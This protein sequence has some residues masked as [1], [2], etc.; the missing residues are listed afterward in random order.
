MP[1]LAIDQV[2]AYRLHK[3]SGHAI[4]TLDG[5]D[6]LLGPHGSDE[7]RRLYSRR[8]AEWLANGRQ[9]AEPASLPGS[10]NVVFGI[11]SRRSGHDCQHWTKHGRRVCLASAFGRAVSEA[12][13]YGKSMSCAGRVLY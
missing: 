1:K 2:P 12:S 4:V 3:Q 13:A 9:L 6:F 11:S 10:A 8:V 7:S 5:R